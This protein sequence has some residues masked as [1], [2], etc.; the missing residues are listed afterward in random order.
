MKKIQ[1]AVIGCGG[2]GP[3][4]LNVFFSNNETKLKWMCDLSAPR[5]E[6]LKQTFH[7]V[8]ATTDYRDILSDP[9]VDLVAMRLRWTA[10]TRWPRK[11]SKLASTCSSKNR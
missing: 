9:K 1:T 11:L 8:Q 5:L 10:T 3:N 7:D 2:W 4:L 6:F